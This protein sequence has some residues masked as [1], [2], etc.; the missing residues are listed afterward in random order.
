LKV[1]VVD[2]SRVARR[3]VTKHL[4]A[5]P[6]DEAAEVLEAPSG[7]EGLALFDTSIDVVIS[8][9]NMP[10]ISGL[11]FVQQL[12]EREK[13]WSRSEAEAVPVVMITTEGTIDKVMEALDSG[14][15]EYVIKPFTAETLIAALNRVMD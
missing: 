15:K 4:Q 9:W 12:R 5:T 2:D 14:V 8:D 11:Q 6:A 1:L 7:E 3:I 13:S 10:G